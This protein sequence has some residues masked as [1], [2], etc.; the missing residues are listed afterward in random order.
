VAVATVSSHRNTGNGA[1]QGFGV[2]QW[3][4]IHSFIDP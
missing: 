3:S 4:A 2:V 1:G